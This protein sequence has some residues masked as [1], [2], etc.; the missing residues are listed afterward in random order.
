LF[1]VFVVV[2]SGKVTF[3]VVSA[4]DFLVFIFCCYLL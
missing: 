1:L 3:A 2:C 4:I